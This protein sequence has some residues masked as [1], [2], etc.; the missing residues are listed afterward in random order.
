MLTAKDAEEDLVRGL[1]LG[2]PVELTESGFRLSRSLARFLGRVY[3]RSGLVERLQGYDLE[4]YGRTIDAH[5]KNLRRK[6][7]D[8]ARSPR[9]VLAAHG[10]GYSFAEDQ[11]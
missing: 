6:L 4:M 2:A 9:Q 1:Q 10:R 3:R 7:G 11:R 5:I 8:E